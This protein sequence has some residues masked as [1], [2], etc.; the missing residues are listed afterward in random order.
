[1]P[2][3]QSAMGFLQKALPWI[4]A[5]ATGN[6][7]MLV[8]MAAK[9]IGDATGGTVDASPEGIAQ[10][11]AGATPEQI[12]AIK[13]ADQDFAVQMQALGYKNVEELSR[14]AANDRADARNRE[15]K[16]GDVWT[17]RILA[18]LVIIGYSLVQ[19]FILTHIVEPEMREIVMRSL[20][21]MDM[22]LGLVLGYYFGSSAASRDNQAA[23]RTAAAK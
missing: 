13:K 14:I 19:W 10:A 17:P 6:V 21:T 12:A 2:D 4:G 7:P 22:A 5:A 18:M 9:A 11:V 23:L 3:I 16:T 1:M 15:I 8:G 20:G